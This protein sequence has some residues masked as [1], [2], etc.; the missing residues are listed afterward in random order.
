MYSAAEFVIDVSGDGLS[1][2]DQRV[3]GNTGPGTAEVP[4]G[5]ISNDFAD[6]ASEAL[7]GTNISSSEA[8]NV[9]NYFNALTQG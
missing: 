8:T 6:R 1:E 4:L 2:T 3:T 5:S 7:D 9:E